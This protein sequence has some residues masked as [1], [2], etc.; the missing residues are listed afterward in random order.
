MF[1]RFWVTLGRYANLCSSSPPSGQAT[2]SAPRPATSGRPRRGPSPRSSRPRARWGG[3]RASRCRFLERMQ[4]PS[5]VHRLANG[6]AD[7]FGDRTFPAQAERLHIRLELRPHRD[8]EHLP[9]HASHL[10]SRS[11]FRHDVDRS[12]TIDSLQWYEL[13]LTYRI[14]RCIVLSV[15]RVRRGG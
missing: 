6:A 9:P 10:L 14:S 5:R 13:L 12:I 8:L 4:A 2:P 11:L 3:W 1:G 7:R 15:A